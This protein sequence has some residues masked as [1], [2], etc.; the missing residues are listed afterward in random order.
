MTRPARCREIIAMIPADP[1]DALIEAIEEERAILDAQRR[2]F[3]GDK[4][5]DS[6]NSRIQSMQVIDTILK[7]AKHK[8][9]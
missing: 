8:R 5:W 2:G 4:E 9:R 1:F 6:A 3:G 7:R